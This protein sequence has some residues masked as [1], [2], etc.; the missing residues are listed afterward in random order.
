MFEMLGRKFWPGPLTL[1]VKAKPVLPL[2]ITAGTGFV[3]IRWPALPLAQQLLD[4]AGVPVAAPSANRFSHVSPTSAS[5]VLADLGQ[6]P[7]MVMAGSVD[8][9]ASKSTAEDGE[10]NGEDTEVCAVGIESTVA[11]IQFGEVEDQPDKLIVYRRGGVAETD[12]KN[13]S[14]LV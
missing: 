13:V 1:I 12:L 10:A 11:K 7:I 14:T 8:E 6:H 9:P 5:H 2:V 3:G 4:A